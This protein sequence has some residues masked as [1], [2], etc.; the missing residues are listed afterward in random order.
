MPISAAPIAAVANTIVEA[1]GKLTGKLRELMGADR[2]SYEEVMNYFIDHKDDNPTIAKGAI[3]K[4][5]A[6]NELTVF[7]VFLDKDNQ[8][9]TDSIGN[10]LGYKK[11]VAN[12]EDELLHL[13]KGGKLIIVE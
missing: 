4:E 8:L 13:F 12:M 9:I 7:Q 11:K 10:P 2:I 1:F 3:L 5:E 6:E